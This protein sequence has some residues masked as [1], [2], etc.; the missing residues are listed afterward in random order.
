MQFR[1]ICLKYNY[2]EIAGQMTGFLFLLRLHGLEAVV[3][4]KADIY[5]INTSYERIA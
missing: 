2:L 5:L 4:P 3:I 1:D